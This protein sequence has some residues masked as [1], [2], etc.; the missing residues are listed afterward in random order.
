VIVPD[1]RRRDITRP[2]GAATANV[3][4]LLI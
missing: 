1:R 2:A 4:T 3:T